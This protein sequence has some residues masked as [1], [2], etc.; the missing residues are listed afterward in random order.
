[1]ENC[2]GEE[3]GPWLWQHG[4]TGRCQAVPAPAHSHC[5]PLLPLNWAPIPSGRTWA[6]FFLFAETIVTVGELNS[7]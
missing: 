3:E 6:A 1:M 4:A 2:W 5:C 7:C